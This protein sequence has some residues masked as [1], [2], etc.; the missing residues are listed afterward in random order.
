M[1]DNVRRV[2]RDAGTNDQRS[3]SKDYHTTHDREGTAKLTT[4]LVHALADV[5]DR[6]VTDAG[7]LLYDSVDPNA[8]DRI[9][10]PTGDGSPRAPGHVAF[11][12][13][14]YRVTVYSDGD[15]VITPPAARSR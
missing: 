5:M 3:P 13:D 4:T 12:V 1:R 15:V 11:V 6:D 7:S 8:I 9:F 14:G 10:S 2:P